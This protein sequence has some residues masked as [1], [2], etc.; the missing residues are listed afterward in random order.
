M[1]YDVEFPDSS[2][3]EYSENFIAKNMYAQVDAEGHV[4]NMTEAIL[5]YKK[6]A[7]AVDK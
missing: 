3:K 1:L 7:P 6:Y 2:I 4:H 5:H